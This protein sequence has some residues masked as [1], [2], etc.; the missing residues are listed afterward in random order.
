MDF[1][2]L[3]SGLGGIVTGL[4]GPI[5]KGIVS[6]K[7]QKLQ[8]EHDENMVK[9]T[10]QATIEEAKAAIQKTETI[11]EGQVKIAETGA[12]TE[13]LKA[14]DRPI[15]NEMYMKYLVQSGKLGQIL[16]SLIAFGLAC[17]DMFRQSI[18]PSVTVYMIAMSTWITILAYTIVNAVEGG[19]TATFAQ[20]IFKMTVYT[21]VYLTVTVV[22]FW[23]VNREKGLLEKISNK[24]K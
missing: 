9:L 20:D 13:A 1:G 8:F 21:V 24:I 5:A 10:T 4:V 22:N 16:V 19:I 3:A 11:T 18:R 17:V 23:F 6:L 2:I 15:F 7:Q 12:L 14:A